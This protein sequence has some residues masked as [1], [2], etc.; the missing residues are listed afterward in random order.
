[1]KEP[2]T[3]TR[4][5]WA[6]DYVLATSLAVKLAPEPPPPVWE[7]G[8]PVRRL[9]TPG[10]PPELRITER[11]DKTRGLGAPSGRARALHT[12]LHHELQAAELMAWAILAF[13]DTP[14]EFRDGLLRIALDEIR[15]MRLYAEQIERLGHRVG[16]F[17]VR[18]WFWTRVPTCADPASF[19]AVM[20]LGLES[21]N[22]EHTTTFAARFREAGDEEGARVQEV[23]GLEE[24][25]HVRFGVRWFEHF[26]GGLEFEAWRRALPAPLTPLLMRGRPL[27]RDA[28]RRAG[29]SDRFLDELEAWQPDPIASPQPGS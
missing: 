24:I 6:W 9:D 17:P 25:A 7:S 11:A 28:R 26:T 16:D 1:M 22:L 13:P 15:H 20:G 10:R 21:A 23:V 19:V 3:G 5:R 4:E 29:Q 27:R 12:F 2:E 14:V 18:D 8:A